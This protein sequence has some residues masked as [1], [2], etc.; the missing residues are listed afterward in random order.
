MTHCASLVSIPT[1]D[2]RR[3][4]MP[5][6]LSF[7]ATFLVG[8]FVVSGCGGADPGD[9]TTKGVEQAMMK[10]DD[11]PGDDDD[12][13]DESIDRSLLGPLQKFIGFAVKTASGQCPDRRAEGGKWEARELVVPYWDAN[14]YRVVT[15]IDAPNCLYFWHAD[16]SAPAP[17]SGAALVSADT[18]QISI[19]YY[20]LPAADERR[21]LPLG[22]GCTDCVIPLGSR[23]QLLSFPADYP[24]R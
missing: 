13:P 6:T 9:S 16:Q 7:A 18:T 2:N 17:R 3:T 14:F 15:A 20:K 10:G 5:N 11:T 22:G 8:V 19:I 23:F 24:S 21:G 1:R 12:A 4:L